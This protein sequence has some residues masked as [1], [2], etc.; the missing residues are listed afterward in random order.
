MSVCKLIDPYEKILKKNNIFYR[1][2]K[3]V[4]NLS[5]MGLENHNSIVVD[6]N[7]EVWEK[8]GSENFIPS[9]IF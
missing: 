1:Q 2:D 9:K 6:D 7:R 4:K 3:T 8:L 5:D